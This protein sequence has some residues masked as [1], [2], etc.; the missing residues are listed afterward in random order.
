MIFEFNAE[1]FKINPYD[2]LIRNSS[3]QYLYNQLKH[4]GIHL[5]FIYDTDLD[6][7]ESFSRGMDNAL[8]KYAKANK[9]DLKNPTKSN[10]LKISRF[11]KRVVVA[12]FNVTPMK[13]TKSEEAKQRDISK[14]ITLNSVCDKKAFIGYTFAK[15][16]E[17]SYLSG[18][19]IAGE[20][21][22]ISEVIEGTEEL[23]RVDPI[24]EFKYKGW[25]DISKELGDQPKDSIVAKVHKDYV[26]VDF[27]INFN[28][29]MSSEEILRNVNFIL[30]KSLCGQ[31]E[32][33][34]P[35]QVEFE[36][37]KD[38]IFY[39][40]MLIKQSEPEI[41]ESMGKATNRLYNINLTHEIKDGYLFSEYSKYEPLGSSGDI[42]I[43]LI[44]G[45][46]H[47][48]NN[49]A[50]GVWYKNKGVYMLKQKTINL[51]TTKYTYVK[52]VKP[53]PYTRKFTFY[54][55]PFFD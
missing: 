47:T 41:V 43:V 32:I 4:Y 37:L 31:S 24:A 2:Q 45:T 30:L 26:K 40:P 27:E 38:Q 23:F 12:N 55:D 50:E 17:D 18:D 34:K 42:K 1:R 13:V 22:P 53:I 9:I 3:L 35:I 10:R 20:I 6:N 28:L 16:K 14:S 29:I 8:V 36:F 49:T 48:L 19:W 54:A 51:E 11:K 39:M 33:P 15:L 25:Q 21:K 44:L 7:K 52:P 46:N 5:E